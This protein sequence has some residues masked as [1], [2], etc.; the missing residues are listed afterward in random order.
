MNA[1]ECGHVV[2]RL[3]DYLDGMLPEAERADIV[4][5]LQHCANCTA[6]FEFEQSFLDTVGRLRRDDREFEPLKDQVIAALKAR[7]FAPP[8]TGRAK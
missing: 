6:H 1:L 4:A 2:R 3:W 7:G 5:H 8:G